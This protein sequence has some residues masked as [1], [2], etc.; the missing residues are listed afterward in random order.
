VTAPV[1]YSSVAE[2]TR[3]SLRPVGPAL[4]A[5]LVV[6]VGAARIW[7][8][9]TLLTLVPL[10]AAW[11]LAGGLAIWRFGLD[12]RER[13]QLARQLRRSRRAAEPAVEF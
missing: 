13:E 12:P 4:V 9:D 6:L 11:A 10:G 1:A 7:S 5:A 3:A 8:P 2:L